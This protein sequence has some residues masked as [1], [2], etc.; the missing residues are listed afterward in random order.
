[1]SVRLMAGL[2][3]LGTFESGL[4]RGLNHERALSQV[5]NTLG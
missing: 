4:P 1:M 3:L 2:Q 5:G